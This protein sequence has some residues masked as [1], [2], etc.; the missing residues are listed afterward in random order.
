MHVL[1][2]AEVNPKAFP[3]ADAAL[4]NSIL[5]LVQQVSSPFG[6]GF[7]T[8]RRFTVQAERNR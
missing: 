2:Q 1:W 3:L 7:R 8:W 5:D 6:P 4:T